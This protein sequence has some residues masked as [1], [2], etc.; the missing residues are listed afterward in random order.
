MARWR[1][2]S[3]R[4]SWRFINSSCSCSSCGGE[5]DGEEDG[6]VGV[7]AKVRAL[8]REEAAAVKR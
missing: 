2:F 7:D 5:E 1:S 3:S 6:L 8:E 4:A